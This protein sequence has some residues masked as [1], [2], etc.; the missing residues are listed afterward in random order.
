MRYLVYIGMVYSKYIET[1]KDYQR[2]SSALQKAP[3]PKCVCF[4]NGTADKEVKKVL[5]LS[6]AFD[7]ESDVEVKVLMININYG[8]NID[9]LKA[10]RPLNEYAWF[11]DKVRYYQKELDNLE[12]AVDAALDEMDDN[13]LLK[14]FLVENKAEVKR[15]C[16]T[17]YDEERT[18]AEKISEG[19]HKRA[20]TVALTML[21]NGE[22]V[23]KTNL[24]SGLPI[25]EVI[26]L[27]KQVKTVPV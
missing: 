10:C 21:K 17:E 23:E 12:D 2:Y 24:Y 22:S 13:S 19:E 27:S 6:D 8:H 16:I 11:V 5:K 4:Y 15:M 18:M 1:T 26:A 3:T 25:E 20:V 14:P 7:G 9:L